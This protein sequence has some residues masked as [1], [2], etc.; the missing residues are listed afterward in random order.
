MSK[1][2]NQKGEQESRDTFHLHLSQPLGRSNVPRFRQDVRS[3][4]LLAHAGYASE[5]ETDTKTSK[6]RE[7]IC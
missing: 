4:I 7:K 3:T 5:R 2:D 6:K 1:G